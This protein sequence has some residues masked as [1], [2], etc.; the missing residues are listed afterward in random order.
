MRRGSRRDLTLTPFNSPSEE[1]VESGSRRDLTA[2]TPF[3][4]PSKEGVRAGSLTALP[5]TALP[6]TPLPP[7]KEGVE[8]RGW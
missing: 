5:L 3:N 7:S 1:G 8:S 4:S 2:L 6:L